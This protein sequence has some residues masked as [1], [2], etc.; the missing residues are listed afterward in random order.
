MQ[1][2][3]APLALSRYVI[4]PWEQVCTSLLTKM[5]INNDSLPISG[6]SLHAFTGESLF[7]SVL[8]LYQPILNE[9]RRDFS[10]CSICLRSLDKAE[11]QRLPCVLSLKRGPWR[12]AF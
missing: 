8:T 4:C 5:D 11:L 7:V 2:L 12:A 3:I 6:A 10:G 1:Q 9:I